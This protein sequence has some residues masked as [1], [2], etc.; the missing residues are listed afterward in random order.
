MLTIR[1]PLA[2]FMGP[3]GALIDS[4]FTTSGTHFRRVN[5]ALWL[6]EREETYGLVLRKK[7]PNFF[8]SESTSMV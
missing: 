1:I 5:S 3:R 8:D 6:L 4:L 7:F 2:E